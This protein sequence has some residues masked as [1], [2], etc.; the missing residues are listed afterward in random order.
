MS[1]KGKLSIL[2]VLIANFFLSLLLADRIWSGKKFQTSLAFLLTP[3]TIFALK[4]SMLNLEHIKKKRYA[5][6]VV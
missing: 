1:R 4:L 5:Y 2:I 6:L 3:F